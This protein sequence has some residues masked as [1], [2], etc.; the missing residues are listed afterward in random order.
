M[1]MA[2]ALTMGRMLTH[3]AVFAIW[4]GPLLEGQRLAREHPL[5]LGASYWFVPAWLIW[6][7]VGPFAIVG[8]LAWYELWDR[9]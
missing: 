3:H 5:V 9:G 1:Y 4:G 8:A 6:W 2:V 7:N